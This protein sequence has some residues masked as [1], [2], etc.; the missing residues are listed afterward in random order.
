MRLSLYAK[1]RAQVGLCADLT[2]T[3]S[4]LNRTVIFG[5]LPCTA[6]SYDDRHTYSKPCEFLSHP[7]SHLLAYLAPAGRVLLLLVFMCKLT[8]SESSS[9][10][11]GPS[12]ALQWDCIRNGHRER[13]SD[14]L[15]Q[16]YSNLAMQDR[17]LSG[18]AS[19]AWRPLRITISRWC[20]SPI[21]VKP[22]GDNF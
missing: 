18:A 21:L 8:H 16:P 5:G 17:I 3:Y 13:S 2:N 10:W 1:N 19:A 20:S 22:C 11:I 6:W 9:V 15:W 12:D 14:M 4:D 7:H